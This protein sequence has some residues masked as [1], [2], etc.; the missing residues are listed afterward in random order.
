MDAPLLTVTV[1]TRNGRHAEIEA[2]GEVD[3]STQELLRDQLLSLVEQGATDLVVDLRDVSFLDS[4]GL[5][6]MIEAIQR[7]ASLRLR[8][9]QPAVRQVFD[10]VTIPQITI[11]G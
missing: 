9:L 6:G 7:G 4:S 2:K 10:I 11:E 5:R 3:V 1:R 8:H